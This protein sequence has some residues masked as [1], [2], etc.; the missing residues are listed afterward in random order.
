MNGNSTKGNGEVYL[1]ILSV[2]TKKRLGPQSDKKELIQQIKILGRISQYISSLPGE[3]RCGSLTV[4]AAMLLPLF[5]WFLSGF[6]YMLLLFRLQEDIGQGLADAGRQLGQYAYSMGAE[7]G[8]LTG[9]SLV[10][11]RQKLG[12]RCKD[13]VALSLIGGKLSAV[14][15]GKSKIM[16]RNAQIELIAEYEIR[17]P[18]MLLG[19]GTLPVRQRQIC[20]AWVG[21]QGAGTEGEWEEMVYVTPYGEVYHRDME[22]RHLKLSIQMTTQAG[23]EAG[24]NK[25]GDRYH[26]CSGCCSEQGSG[27]VYVTDYGNRY[28]QDLNCQGLKRT[29]YLVFASEAQ[30]KGVCKSCGGE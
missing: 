7:Q 23:A 28:H 19:T 29:V 11:V 30:G 18:W 22:C 8:G 15:L 2:H 16:E 10:Q 13:S 12:A 9:V 20:R 6:L 27:S 17:N 1:D 5:W 26:A 25:N 14:R 21:S 3:R 4:E 24:R